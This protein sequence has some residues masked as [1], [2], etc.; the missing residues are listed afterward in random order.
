MV[1]VDPNTHRETERMRRLAGSPPK[2]IP[3]AT[4]A[5][6]EDTLGEERFASMKKNGLT[7]ME[8]I[9]VQAH[10]QSLADIEAVL[11]A[12]RLA[13]LQAARRAK[14]K[15]GSP[16]ALEEVMGEEERK[17]VQ[18]HAESG[19]AK[20]AMVDFSGVNVTERARPYIEVARPDPYLGKEETQPYRR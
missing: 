2:E 13:A 7:V 1:A 4:R 18:A 19:Q 12:E 8:V 6:I 17:R 20:H 5:L 15:E 10:A 9:S 16:A 14:A 3:G 11:G